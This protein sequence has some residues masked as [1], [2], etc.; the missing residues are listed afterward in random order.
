MNTKLKLKVVGLIIIFLSLVGYVH[1]SD[2]NKVKHEKIVKQRKEYTGKKLSG[3][4]NYN[5]DGKITKGVIYNER[6]K[7]TETIKFYYDDDNLIKLEIFNMNKRKKYSKHYKYENDKVVLA[8]HV[9]HI[10]NGRTDG[11]FTYQYDDNGNSVV[12]KEYDKYGIS[13]SFKLFYD[14]NN[15]PVKINERDYTGGNKNPPVKTSYISYKYN[16]NNMILVS[17]EKWKTADSNKTRLWE[18]N[19]YKYDKH[20]NIIKKTRYNYMFKTTKA[21]VNKYNKNNDIVE[22]KVYENKKRI[23]S[24]KYKY[25]YY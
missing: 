21:E 19:T 9:D 23:E 20:N 12:E 22:K 7:I 15:N 10:N 11:K 14:K 25:T 2:K 13:M 24:Y 1:S 8:K 17:K 18:K 3:I 5:S 6:G 4:N 16:K